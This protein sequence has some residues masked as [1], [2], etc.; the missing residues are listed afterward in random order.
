[1][2]CA[3]IRHPC[4]IGTSFLIVFSAATEAFP[5]KQ[6]AAVYNALASS[7][8]EEEIL[9][10]CNRDD[11]VELV[12]RQALGKL[13][14]WEAGTSIEVLLK[15][16]QDKEKRRLED[17]VDVGYV[18]RHNIEQ[19]LS[20]EAIK[21]LL[22]VADRFP[23]LI[24]DEE[25]S[26]LSSNEAVNIPLDEDVPDE[27]LVRQHTMQA[28]FGAAKSRGLDRDGFEAIARSIFKDTAFPGTFNAVVA[29]DY[30]PSLLNSAGAGSVYSDTVNIHLAAGNACKQWC[31]AAGKDSDETSE[32]FLAVFK[33]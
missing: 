15:K 25:S 24:K 21:K 23:E 2:A 31:K 28:A 19:V 32:L 20:A 11:V 17:N 30:E 10:E 27:E 6:A 1:M 33:G 12:V 5:H 9:K 18:T 13:V 4:R 16:L 3:F 26:S 14:K 29:I 7:D 8:K 22:K